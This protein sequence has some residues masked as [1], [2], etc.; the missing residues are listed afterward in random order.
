[1]Y[2]GQKA[3]DDKSVAMIRDTKDSDNARNT[4]FCPLISRHWL[5]KDL[6]ITWVLAD[7]NTEMICPM[8]CG[9]G[10]LLLEQVNGC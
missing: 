7:R 3:K 9:E 6:M 10:G 1:L 8:F 4:K 5:S 2:N